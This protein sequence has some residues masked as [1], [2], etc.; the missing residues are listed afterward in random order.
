MSWRRLLAIMLLLMLVAC[1]RQPETA[2]EEFLAMGTL[3]N[4]S[5]YGEDEDRVQ[6]L[7]GQVREAFDRLNNAWHPWQGGALADLNKSLATQKDVTIDPSL[8]PLINE[9]MTLEAQSDS[10]FDPAI[11]GLVRLWGFDKDEPPSGPPPSQEAIDQWLKSHPRLADLSISDSTLRSL[12]PAVVLDFGGF[13]KGAA[14]DQVIDELRAEGVKNAI[15]NAGGD[16]RAIG[17]KGGKPWVIG[18]RHPRGE[19]VLA[20]LEVSGDESV[21]T[22]GDYERFYEYQG[23]RYH[24]ILD[25]RSGYPAR[26]LTSVTVLHKKASVADAACTA[27]FVAGPKDWP[28]IARRMGVTAVMVVDQQGKVTMTPEMAARI[29]FET[30]EQPESSV[31]SLDDPS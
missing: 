14:V 28:R 1:D 24:H 13:A 21:F 6:K 8:Q 15:V 31:I 4:L 19:G 7:S 22:S 11:G 30:A 16:L 25:P 29:H 20:S 2:R 27:L 23:K 3:I 9:A 5:F 17:D 10:L 26:G 12:N 18:I